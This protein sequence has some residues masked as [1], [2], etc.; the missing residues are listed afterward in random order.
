MFWKLE[1]TCFEIQYFFN[2]LVVDVGLYL[3]TSSSH[4]LENVLNTPLFVNNIILS[5]L[6][7]LVI[8]VGTKKVKQKLS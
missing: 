3:I 2:M 8:T 7:Y 5:T 6:G 4:H 1:Q